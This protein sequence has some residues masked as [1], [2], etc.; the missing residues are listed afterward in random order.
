MELRRFCPFCAAP[1]G[2][3]VDGV[4]ACP[5]CGRPFYHNAAPCAAVLVED[6]GRVLMARRAVDPGAGLWDLPGGF[7]GPE[8][9]PEETAVRELWEETGAQVT[10]T[11]S[12]GT[13]HST[14]GA[15]T[16]SGA[17]AP[18]Q[19]RLEPDRSRD[20]R[21]RDAAC[22]RAGLGHADRAAVRPDA[23]HAER[24]E[25][26]GARSARRQPECLCHR[27]L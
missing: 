18:S 27:M 24:P 21:R 20:R 23:A 3:V 4:Q 2:R 12:P 11:G 22:Q 16:S 8:E 17:T 1:L 5:G 14:T 9:A 13:R 19:G 6:A 25:P 10:V 15:A 7:C 26:D